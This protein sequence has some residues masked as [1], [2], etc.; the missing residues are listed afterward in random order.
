MKPFKSE[1]FCRATDIK[2]SIYKTSFI[3]GSHTSIINNCS[4]HK[5]AWYM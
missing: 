4:E 2:N 3:D 1:I 5:A